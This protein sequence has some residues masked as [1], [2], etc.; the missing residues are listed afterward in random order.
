MAPKTPKGLKAV[1]TVVLP[2]EDAKGKLPPGKPSQRRR[3]A[4]KTA[5]GRVGTYKAKVT[6]L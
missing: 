4:V 6:L 2:G 3:C 1:L 5:F